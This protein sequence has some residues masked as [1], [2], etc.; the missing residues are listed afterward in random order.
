MCLYCYN[1]G[2]IQGLWD[3]CVVCWEIPTIEPL[4]TPVH[5]EEIYWDSPSVFMGSAFFLTVGGMLSGLFFQSELDLRV[6]F[7]YNSLGLDIPIPFHEL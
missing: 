6:N 1:G 7:C 2:I 4:K 3:F 5:E